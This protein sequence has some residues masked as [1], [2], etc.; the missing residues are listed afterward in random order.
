[1]TQF[2]ATLNFRDMVP[3][4]GLTPENYRITCF[5]LCDP[6]PRKVIIRNS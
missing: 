1:M 2:F 5:R 6:D 3:L 4:P